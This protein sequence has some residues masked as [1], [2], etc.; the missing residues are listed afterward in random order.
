MNVLK[1]YFFFI[2]SLINHAFIIIALLIVIFVTFSSFVTIYWFLSFWILIGLIILCP[3]RVSFIN[4]L[5]FLVF[6]NLILVDFNVVTFI[7]SWNPWCSWLLSPMMKS[8]L[9][10]FLIFKLLSSLII[11]VLLRRFFI[12][13]LLSLIWHKVIL[14]C[15]STI[16]LDLTSDINVIYALK[17]ILYCLFTVIS[18]QR[19]LNIFTLKLNEWLICLDWSLVF[20]YLLFFWWNIRL[21]LHKC[22][23]IRF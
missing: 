2:L 12:S 16:I 13:Y 9:L 5:C 22:I 3:S 7:F 21:N 11:K 4:L 15:L 20:G 19:L 17:V 6:I 23:S 8:S 1:I 18:V 10:L 14:L